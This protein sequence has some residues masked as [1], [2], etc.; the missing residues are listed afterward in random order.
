M[1]SYTANLSRIGQQLLG[2]DAAWEKVGKLQ[3]D[4][5]RSRFLL[6]FQGWQYPWYWSATVLAVL[7]GLSV[8]ILNLSVKS[9]DR[10][11]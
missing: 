6:R 10:L 5:A 2:T 11:K 4:K 3:S 1:V 8:C 9:L 7:L